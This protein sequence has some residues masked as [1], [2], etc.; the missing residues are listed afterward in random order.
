MSLV[1]DKS[2][3]IGKAYRILT[4]CAQDSSSLAQQVWYNLLTHLAIATL[5][6]KNSEAIIQERSRRRSAS[7][8]NQDARDA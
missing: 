2:T 6:K 5:L 7:A 8:Q 1:L 4:G 3:V